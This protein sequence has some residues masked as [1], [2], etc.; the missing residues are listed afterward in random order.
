M[1]NYTDPSIDQP[2]GIAVGPDGALWF[3]NEGTESESARSTPPL[4]ASLLRES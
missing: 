3:I 2:A 4:G 1:S